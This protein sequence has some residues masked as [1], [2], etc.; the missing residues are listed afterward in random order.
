MKNFRI[1]LLLC[2]YHFGFCTEGYSQQTAEKKI[3]IYNAIITTS[4]K[5]K[6]SGVFLEVQD[7]S[8]TI[9]SSDEKIKVPATSIMVIKIKRKGAVGRGATIGGLSGVGL[10]LII[11]LAS[12]DDE[13]PQG[14]WCIYQMS[15][16]DKALAGG[17]A[18]G[19]SGTIVGMTI[20]AVS[21]AE[22][23]HVNGDAKI[24][25]NNV[26]KMKTYVQFK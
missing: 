25:Q 10:G 12:G 3:K 16:G 23:I 13:C 5:Q 2:I 15:A 4:Q 7:S 26:E 1:L 11:G 21:R 24:F 18:L 20:G 14:S 17:L 8:V 22:K 6:L 9:I 19:I